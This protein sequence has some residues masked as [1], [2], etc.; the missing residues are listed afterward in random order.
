VNKSVFT[1]LKVP[2][3]VIGNGIDNSKPLNPKL[4]RWQGREIKILFNDCKVVLLFN[5]QTN[6]EEK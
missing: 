5:G 3:V 4:N 6:G 1:K 2:L